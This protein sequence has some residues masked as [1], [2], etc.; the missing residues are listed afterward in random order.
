M[1]MKFGGA[2]ID[3]ND[4]PGHFTNMIAMLDL[5]LG[6]DPG[7]FFIVYPGVFCTLHNF[8]SV[9]FSGLRVHGGS[10]P[11]APENATEYEKKWA[12]RCTVVAYAK[13]GPTSTEHKMP[14]IQLEHNNLLSI[15]PEMLRPEYVKFLIFILI[16]LVVKLISRCCE[17]IDVL[18]WRRS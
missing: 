8:V 16:L 15:T 5:P 2:H 7:R 3:Q 11:I 12:T 13:T 17:R 9:N 14:L 10:P 4:S 1:G 6:S 18:C